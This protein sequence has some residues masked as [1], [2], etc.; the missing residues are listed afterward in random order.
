MP[1]SNILKCYSRRIEDIT[2]IF[3]PLIY[4]ELLCLSY[5]KK[6]QRTH[7]YY[8]IS[9]AIALFSYTRYI[10]QYY[11]LTIFFNSSQINQR[12]GAKL[13]NNLGPKIS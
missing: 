2:H 6:K 1:I 13:I 8:V 12:Y 5:K 7:Y 3:D 4:V 11:L 9:N 10:C